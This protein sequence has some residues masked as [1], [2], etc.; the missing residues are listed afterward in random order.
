MNEEETKELNII[1]EEETYLTALSD[2]GIEGVEVNPA[3]IPIPLVRLVQGTSQN[4]EIEDGKDAAVGT[5]HFSDTK[6]A[7]EKLEFILLKA[8]QTKATF[9]RDGEMVTVDKMLLLGYLK[10]SDKVF[11]LSL[12]ATSFSPFGSLIARLKDKKVKKIYEY[13]VIA[14]S[15]KTENE[16]GKFYIINF[17]LGNPLNEKEIK[18]YDSLAQKYSSSLKGQTV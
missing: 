9:E 15:L 11:I 6:T 18:D 7:V 8:K 10:E 1:K 16:K 2:F 3:I 17:E 5:F 12:P 14:T 4:I 13:G